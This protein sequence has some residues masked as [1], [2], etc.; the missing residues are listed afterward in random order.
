MNTL[1]VDNSILYENYGMSTIED[2]HL[3]LFYLA[4]NRQVTDKM[5]DKKK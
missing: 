3:C 4:V 2:V 1:F 5:C